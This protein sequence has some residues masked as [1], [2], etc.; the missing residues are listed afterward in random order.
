[1]YEHGQRFF[2]SS[3]WILIE[4]RNCTLNNGQTRIANKWN[5]SFKCKT[6]I[7]I[8]TQSSFHIMI[9]Q[10][11]NALIHLKAFYSNSSRNNEKEKKTNLWIVCFSSFCIIYWRL[12]LVLNIRICFQ[13]A[14]RYIVV[15]AIIENTFL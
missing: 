3:P 13:S 2:F 9:Y 15:V 7:T 14:I 1:M 4:C 10:I 5:C 12:F 11:R 6:N 8:L